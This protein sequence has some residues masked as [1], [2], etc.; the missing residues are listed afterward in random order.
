MLQK[1]YKKLFFP[2]TIKLDTSITYLGTAGISP[3]II[4]I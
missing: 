3:T 1:F 4:K 2:T